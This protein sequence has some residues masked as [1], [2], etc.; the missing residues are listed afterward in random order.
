MERDPDA[1]KWN[2]EDMSVMM[3]R[4]LIRANKIE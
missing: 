1:P 2:H 3:L 4:E